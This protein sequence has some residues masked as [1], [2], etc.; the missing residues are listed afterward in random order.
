MEIKNTRYYTRTGILV[1]LCEEHEDYLKNPSREHCIGPKM[2]G[3]L[4]DCLQ[5]DEFDPK[6]HKGLKLYKFY[7]NSPFTKGRI[8]Q[9]IYFETHPILLP[10]SLIITYDEYNK[11]N[12]PRNITTKFTINAFKE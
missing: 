4:L 12:R 10:K 2:E 5:V 3:I 11:L 7:A 8:E 1:N 9:V 6:N